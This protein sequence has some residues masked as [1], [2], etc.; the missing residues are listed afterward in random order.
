M[1]R[2]SSR[3]ELERGDA[4]QRSSVSGSG[5]GSSVACRHLRI[6][7]WILV[8]MGPLAFLG[9]L[10]LG[11]IP[12]P[13]LGGSVFHFYMVTTISAIVFTLAVVMRVAA[14]QLRD[15]RAL[16]LSLAYLTISGIFLVH[17]LTTPGVLVGMN[18][19]VGFSSG[20]SP[21]LGA[22]FL[23]LSTIYWSPRVRA[24]IVDWQ[25]WITVAWGSVLVLF[26]AGALF[27]AARERYPGG[28]PDAL[29]GPAAGNLLI[30]AT[31][32]MLVVVI[33]RY[34]WIYRS[35]RSPLVTGI[36]VSSLFLAQ[37]QVS[38][39]FAPI[40][41]VSWWTYHVLL[42]AGFGAA[43]VTL[44]VEYRRSGS[45]QGVVGGLLL[46]DSMTQ[47]QRGYTDVIVALIEAVEAKD[48]Y[49]RGHTQRVAELSQL[50]AQDL[51]LNRREQGVLH[52][53]AV[54][55]DIGKIGIPDA[56]LNKPGGLCEAEFEIIKEHPVRGYR[57]IRHVKSLRQQAEGV[58]HHHERLDGSGYPDGLRGD[59][60]PFIARIIAV[61]DVFDALT[62]ERPYRRAYSVDEALEIIR[63]ESGV[64][65]DA[66]C[67]AALMRAVPVW[68][69][70]STRPDSRVR[71]LTNPVMASGVNT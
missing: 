11:A 38:I 69:G 25:G 41:Q 32:A 56:V 51:G 45:V 36:L 9:L 23:V 68:Q 15:P 67:T 30:A 4:K 57:M 33:G 21:L 40:W 60:I 66:A 53:A 1:I 59:G 7:L 58:R 19:W 62:S 24:A 14:G 5:A 54:L 2:P 71:Q 63:Q 17:A 31:S 35:S 34:V 8:A 42:L 22:M 28:L 50:I 12:D 65:L 13:S 44:Y 43:L 70:R 37:S 64:K 20:L 27:T 39:I 3:I 10:Y 61:A 47:L 16:F 18:P 52:Q 26:A 49:T 55:H 6:L 46:R 48:P 29:I